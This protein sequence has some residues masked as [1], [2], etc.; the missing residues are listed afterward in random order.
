MINLLYVKGYKSI[1]NLKLPLGRVNVIIGE[2]GAGK[3]NI[4][5]AIALA[6]A[7]SAGKLDNEFLA[8]RGI[9][10]TPP[11]YMRP[12]FPD[13]SIERPIE[14]SANDEKT[15]ISFKLTNDNAPY[16]KWESRIFNATN[17][18]NLTNAPERLNKLKH[19]AIN[20]DTLDVFR[21]TLKEILGQLSDTLDNAK[22]ISSTIKKEIKSKNQ[23]MADNIIKEL[24]FKES[25]NTTSDTLSKFII[26]SPEN[27]SLKTFEKEGQIEPLGI[28]GEGL[29]RLLQVI[30]LDESQR[31]IL[32][33]IT[34]SLKVLGW[35]KAFE[36]KSESTGSRIEIEDKYIDN[37]KKYFNQLSV[38]EGF[39]FLLFYFT[40]FSSN[41]TPKFFAIDNIDAS[42]NPKLCQKLMQIITKLA[43]KYDKQVIL[44]THNPAIL[45]GLNLDDDNQRLFVISRNRLGFTRAERKEKP[46]QSSDEKPIR[47]SEAFLRGS[48]GGLPSGF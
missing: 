46:I 3:S 16:S 1:D 10:V 14:I 21:E 30:S 26:Y 48:L 23:E 20:T 6:G 31:D 18:F 12:A 32:N 15:K 25:T 38:N 5:E 11:E 19:E 44:T 33:E 2:N 8:S 28:N 9:R 13:C 42:L 22:N 43:E 41:L 24:I 37:S 4:L 27:S 34:K 47:L 35:F 29:L 17:T 39:L 45:D 40:L 7:A 36:V